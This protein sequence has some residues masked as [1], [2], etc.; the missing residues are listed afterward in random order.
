MA[1][2]SASIAFHLQ[3]CMNSHSH[4]I[5]SIVGTNSDKKQA[6]VKLN[7]NQLARTHAVGFI[8]RIMCLL[9]KTFN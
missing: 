4:A 8:C 2:A 7:E 9:A 1:Y 5:H 6:E 3:T